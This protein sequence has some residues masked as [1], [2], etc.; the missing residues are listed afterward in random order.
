MITAIGIDIGGTKCAVCLGT[1]DNGIASVIDKAPIRDTKQ[2]NSP[3]ELLARLKDDVLALL[4]SHPQYHPT[5]MGISCGG[6]LNHERGVILSPPNLPGW[7]EIYVCDYF[8]QHTGIKAYLCNDANSCALAEWRMGAG[9]GCKNM[10]FMTFGTGLG[11]GLIL[12]GKLYNGTNDMA[13]ELGHFRLCDHG[14]VGYGK[15]GSFEGFC[16]GGGIASLA[17]QYATEQLQQG[18]S[19]SWCKTVDELD[20]ITAKKVGIAAENGDPLALQIY[21][22]SGRMLGKGLSFIIDLLNPQKIVIG[23]IFGKSYN[24]IWPHTKAVLEKEVL[25]HS[26]SVCEVVPAKLGGIIGDVAALIVADYYSSLYK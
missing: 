8:E 16:S 20:D 10:V 23:S 4:E 7:D 2:Y 13:G 5:A 22:E 3:Q 15:A 25:P 18:K 24:E 26:L 21:A 12:D 11:G 14:P 1:V 6:P 19:V 17:R 9:M